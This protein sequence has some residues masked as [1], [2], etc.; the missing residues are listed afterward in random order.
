MVIL[1]WNVSLG[2]LMTVILRLEVVQNMLVQSHGFEASI[3]G[4]TSGLRITHQNSLETET[5]V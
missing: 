4:T 1:L 2:I 5:K 3:L